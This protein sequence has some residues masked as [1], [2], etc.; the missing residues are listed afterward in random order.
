M[1]LVTAGVLG[2]KVCREV[3]ESAC[4]SQALESA[5]LPSLGLPAPACPPRFEQKP[6]AELPLFILKMM[7]LV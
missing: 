3:A 2:S 6:L 1:A 5:R 4:G 7:I